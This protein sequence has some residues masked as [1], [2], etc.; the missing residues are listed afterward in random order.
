MSRLRDFLTSAL[1]ALSL[2]AIGC[3]AEAPAAPSPSPAAS[4]SAAASPSAAPSGTPST[5]PSGTPQASLSS[6]PLLTTTNF[7]VP[8]E[9]FPTIKGGRYVMK[10]TD[11]QS[12]RK[13]REWTEE[14]RVEDVVGDLTQMVVTTSMNGQKLRTGLWLI[15]RPDGLWAKMSE[16]SREPGKDTHSIKG[17][18]LIFKFPMTPNTKWDLIL[19]QG[20]RGTRV[21]VG[22]ETVTVPAGTFR[23]VL[24]RETRGNVTGESWYVP[25][26]G[27]VK[28]D[29]S[30]AA[31]RH[32]KELVQY[33]PATP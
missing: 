8:R 17:A 3:K 14:T 15:S 22:A 30:G 5:A 19:P 33:E 27:M 1:L 11:Y 6:S 4:S 20:T 23:A 24:M 28:S 21:V 29:L 18:T 13:T 32:V 9:S 31:E 2:V 7:S 12:G 25:D 10:Y 26:I 16:P